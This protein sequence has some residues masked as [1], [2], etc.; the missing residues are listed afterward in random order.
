[1]NRTMLILLLLVLACTFSSAQNR[2]GPAL[3]NGLGVRPLE[4]ELRFP[5]V[6]NPLGNIEGVEAT[7][8]LGFGIEFRYNLDNKTKW[9]LFVKRKELAAKKRAER[10]EAAKDIAKYLSKRGIY[11]VALDLIDEKVTEINVTSPCYFFREMNRLHGIEFNKTVMEDLIN[12]T[13]NEMTAAL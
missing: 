1:M 8:N 5:A 12:L 4:V 3:R 7:A 2:Q 10:K 13:E 6:T 11:M 9:N